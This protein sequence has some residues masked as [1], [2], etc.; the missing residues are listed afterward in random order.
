MAGANVTVAAVAKGTANVTVTATD[1]GGLNATQTFQATVPNQAP[2]GVGTIPA[3]TV[4]V[5]DPATLDVS[6]YFDDPDG[7][8]LTY[9][10]TSSNSHV[11]T[12]S[13]AGANLTVTAVAKGTANVTVTATDSGGLT[14]TQTFRVTVPNRPPQR[15]G[16]IPAQ[17]ITEGQSETV[18]MSSYFTDPDGDALTYSASSS[19]TGV[20]RVSVAGSVVTISAVAVGST[21]F[22]VTARDPGG[23]TATQTASVTV[24]RA[25]RAP[26]RVGSI[27]TQTLDSGG[28]AT[29]DASR[30]F[31][32][33]DGDALTYSAS[34]SNTG[35][36]RVSVS[37]STVTISAA[38]VG[39]AMVT[40]TATDPGGLTATQSI[41]VSVSAAAKPDLLVGEVTPTALT[42]TRGGSDAVTFTI[43][44]AGNANSPPTNGRAHQSPDATITTSDRVGSDPIAI[45]G[46]MPAATTR[47]ELTVRIP[48]NFQPGHFYL[49]MCVDPVA[50]ESNTANNCSSGA[51]VNI[52]SASSTLS[53]TVTDGRK[54][55]LPVPGATVRLGNGTN[56]ST[57]TDAR[58]RYRFHNVS[59]RVEVTVSAHP[60]YR[61]QTTEVTVGSDCTLDFTLEHTGIPPFSG[62]VWV[63]PEILGSWRPNVA[64]QR[65]LY[66]FAH[67]GDL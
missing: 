64:G 51:R 49:G 18:N 47:I 55:G 3:R 39:S 35:V 54:A 7:D 66:R 36:A 31:S 29:L 65:N 59:G 53:G 4:Q 57:T 60:S 23:L 13:T 16:T 19:N 15:Q 5:G 46:L 63:T 11:A 14:A 8:P 25:N 37:G 34:S 1:P 48:V 30:Y 17:T 42:I 61:E 26:Q 22:T 12:V 67:A 27:Q 10:A 62:T 21:T 56:E 6:Q 58:G 2:Q 38:G 33:P 41:S 43:R 52:V 20:A 45:R 9:T 50:G 44:N 28:T 40:V 32:D 24:N